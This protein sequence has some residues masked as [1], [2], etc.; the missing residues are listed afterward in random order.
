MPDIWLTLLCTPSLEEKIIDHLLVSVG[1]RIFTSATVAAHGLSTDALNPVER[2]M[3]RARAVQIQLVVE[4]QHL[5]PLL[6]SLRQEF[7]NTGVRYW[8][9]RVS[10]FGEFM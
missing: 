7:P 1:T 4:Q 8:T 5:E 2:V 10:E 9:V 6:D 3:G